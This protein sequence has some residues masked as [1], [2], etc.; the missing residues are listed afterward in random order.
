MPITEG[1]RQWIGYVVLVLHGLVILAGFFIKHAWKL[2][3]TVFTGEAIDQDSSSH[4]T[5]GDTNLVPSIH[6]DSLDT[7]STADLLEYH[8]RGLGQQALLITHLDQPLF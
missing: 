1:T 6:M 2:Y 3:E 5:G 7:H 8:H 4:T